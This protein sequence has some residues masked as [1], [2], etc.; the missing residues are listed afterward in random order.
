MISDLIETNLSNITKYNKKDIEK[1]RCCNKL[2]S[3]GVI[4]SSSYLYAICCKGYVNTGIY[5][6]TDYVGISVNG[7][8][9]N[10]IKIDETELFLALNAKATIITDSKFDRER[11]YNIGEREV[12]NILLNN[13]YHEYLNGLWVHVNN[14]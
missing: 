5:I 3:R 12:A 6:P 11:P 14:I 13:D 8:R 9:T 4:N 10:R 1:F 7:N 2:I